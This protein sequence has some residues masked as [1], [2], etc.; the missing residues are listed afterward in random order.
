MQTGSVALHMRASK[1]KTWI[2]GGNHMAAYLIVDTKISNP[3]AYEEYKALAAPIAAKFGGVYRARGGE[4]HI[5]EAELWSPTRVVV[6]EFPDMASARGYID[7]PEYQPVKAIR[8]AN[9]ECTLFLL[10]GV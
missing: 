7:A 3:E 6:I 5:A 2:F 1:R 4:L 9:A 10:E 8:N